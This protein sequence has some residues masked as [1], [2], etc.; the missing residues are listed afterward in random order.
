MK[1]AAVV[2]LLLVVT[3]VVLDR[4][5]VGFAEREVAER[6][7]AQ[8]ALSGEPD[9]EV[10]GFPFLTQALAGRY[11]EVRISLT[12]DELGQ[13]EGTRADVSLRGVHLPLSALRAGTVAEVPV[14]RIDGTATLSYELLAGELGADTTLEREGDGLRITRTVELL[15][16][17]FPLTAAGTVSLDGDEL[18]IDVDRASGVGV[19]VPRVAVERATDL[20]DLRYPVELPYGLRLTDVTP[21]DDGVAVRA[22]AEDAVLAAE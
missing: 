2:L 21:R 15:G 12:A 22:V 16:R 6:L 18:V 7:A 1:V 9:V 13:P 17:A 8:E 11:D 4:V 3:G 20:L 14:E 10:R 5:A 19:D